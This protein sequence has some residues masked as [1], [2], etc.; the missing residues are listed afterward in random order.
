MPEDKSPTSWRR[1]RKEGEETGALLMSSVAELTILRLPYCLLPDFLLQQRINKS[2]FLPLSLL[3]FHVVES[4][5]SNTIR[6]VLPEIEK[7]LD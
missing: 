5:L 1:Q 7:G 4:V 2:S 3:P 6:S